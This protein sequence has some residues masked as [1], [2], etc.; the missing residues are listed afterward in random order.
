MAIAKIVTINYET[1]EQATTMAAKINASEDS[2]MIRAISNG[3]SL[4]IVP[5]N[6]VF[7]DLCGLF[8]KITAGIGFL[9]NR[10]EGNSKK[11][12]TADA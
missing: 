10:Y 8:S 6:P 12:N 11:A 5:S 4:E 7:A 9:F 2:G 1:S 3:R